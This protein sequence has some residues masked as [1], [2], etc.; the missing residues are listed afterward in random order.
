MACSV[1]ATYSTWVNLASA[2]SHHQA[3]AEAESTSKG[4]YDGHAGMYSVWWCEASAASGPEKFI[5]A[6]Y[7][8]MHVEP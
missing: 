8:I 4:P 6:C 5:A 1:V 2:P 3:A 7:A